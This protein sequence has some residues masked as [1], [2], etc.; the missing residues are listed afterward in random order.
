MILIRTIK[1]M[2]KISNE[3]TTLNEI[4]KYETKSE[5]QLHTKYLKYET[6]HLITK[7]N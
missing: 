6:P 7:H 4:I 1:N 2:R 5:K 3:N